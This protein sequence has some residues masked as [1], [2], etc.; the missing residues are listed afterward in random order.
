MKGTQKAW[1]AA[2]MTLIAVPLAMVFGTGMP[3]PDTL[4]EATM[5]VLTALATSVSAWV[6]TYFKRNQ[7]K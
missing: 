4:G 2:L 7:T 1:A 3:T 6:V 5:V